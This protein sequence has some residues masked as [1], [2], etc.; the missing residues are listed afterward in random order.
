MNQDKKEEVGDLIQVE[1]KLSR[2]TLR[3]LYRP[4]W[5]TVAQSRL[6]ATFDSLILLLAQPPNREGFSPSWPGRSTDLVIHPPWPPKVLELQALAI[7]PGRETESRSI[8]R[9]KCSGVTPAHC[10]FCFPVFKQFS[11]LSLPSSWDYRQAPSRLANFLVSLCCPGL[12][13]V[14]Q[15]PLTTTSAFRSLALSLRLECSGMILTHCNL[16]LPGSSDSPAPA[17]QVAE[18]TEAESKQKVDVLQCGEDTGT[19]RG[20]YDGGH[21]AKALIPVERRLVAISRDNLLNAETKPSVTPTWNL[22]LLLSWSAV[23]QSWLTATSASRIQAILLPQPPEELGLQVQGCCS[24]LLSWKNQSSAPNELRSHSVTQAGV[25]WCNFSSLQPP[26]TEMGFYHVGQAGLKPLTSNDLPTSASQSVGVTGMSHCAW[27]VTYFLMTESCSVAQ[28]GVQWR[29]LGSLQPL[30]PELNLNFLLR[31][32]KVQK[33][34]H[35]SSKDPNLIICA[36]TAYCNLHLPGSSYPPTSA[37]QVAETTGRY[38][39]AWLAKFPS[40]LNSHRWLAATE[41]DST[42][43]EQQNIFILAENALEQHQRITQS[44]MALYRLA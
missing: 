31:Q 28:S 25:Q 33:L 34:I 37:S 42:D 18:T 11:C 13:A 12:S 32:L 24:P 5:S 2:A 6:T 30:P 40:S 38:H 35:I 15:S 3:S 9:L 43:T 8:A 44:S 36:I 23:V 39:H 20:H 21:E 16:C 41:L 14:V 10:N 7:V 4:D 29:D 26:P 19:D 22:A 1:L 17:S 27:P